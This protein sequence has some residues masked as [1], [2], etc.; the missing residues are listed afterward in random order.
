LKRTGHRDQERQVTATINRQKQADMAWP[1]LWFH[2]VFF[3]YTSDYGASPGRPLW[4]LFGFIVV[5]MFFYVEPIADHSPAKSAGIWRVW[6]KERVQRDATADTP[7]RLT[8]W[9]WSAF[10]WALYFSLLSAFHIG[11]REL[12]VGNWIARIQRREY[13][14]RATGWVRVVS[15]I[16]SL[17]S[18]YLLALWALTYF[19]R[20]FD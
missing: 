17:I 9:R 2:R 12:N 1:E 19:G 4:I 15:G 7:E 8:G 5:F 16:Q 6:D 11:W 10:G 13:V 20:P 14:L 3:E 18:V